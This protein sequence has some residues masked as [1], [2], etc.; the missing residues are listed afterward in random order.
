MSRS[1]LIL[2]A[3]ALAALASADT[4]TAQTATRR[5]PPPNTGPTSATTEYPALQRQLS[6]QRRAMKKQKRANCERQAARSKQSYRRF[7]RQCL[8]G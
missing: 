3:V 6:P 4:A 2:V 8:K 7:M 5:P 1:R